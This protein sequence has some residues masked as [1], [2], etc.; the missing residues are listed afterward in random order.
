[1]EKRDYKR[2]YSKY[3]AKYL[4]L[5][6]T[7]DNSYTLRKIDKIDDRTLD[8]D[9]IDNLSDTT[10][11][12]WPSISNKV[13]PSVVQVHSISYTIDPEHPYI[14]PANELA[15]GSGFIIHSSSDSINYD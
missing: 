8:D 4:L 3:K 10:Q 2:L 15:R 13:R 7:V 11:P 6:K 1:M 14:Q 9:N 5:T 12:D